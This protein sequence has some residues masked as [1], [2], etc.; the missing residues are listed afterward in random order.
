MGKAQQPQPSGLGWAL[1][2]VKELQLVRAT[3]AYP[4]SYRYNASGAM[5]K[6]A[7]NHPNYKWWAFGAV[8]IGNVSSSLTHSSAI[9]ALPS[10]ALHFQTDLPTVQWIILAEVLAT[11]ALLLPMGRLS[12]IIGRKQVY[13][14]GLATFAVGGALAGTAANMTTMIIAMLIQGC[15]AAMI[16]GIG[17]ALVASL[18][19]ANERGKGLGAHMSAI[20][21]GAVVG[22]ALGGLMIAVFG[23]RAV[24]FIPV[25]MSIIATAVSV[26]I[27]HGNVFNRDTQRPQ[28]DWLGAFLCAGALV[29][30]L[31]AMTHGYRAGLTS[32]LMAGTSAGFVFFLAAFIW[33]QLRTAS[34]LLDLKLFRRPVFAL[35]VSAGFLTFVGGTSVRFLMPFYL[36]TI[37][38]FTPAQVG[39]IMVPNA[40]C[41]IALGPLSGRLS[42][43]YGFRKFTVGGLAIST[44]GMLLLVGANQSTHLALLIAAMVLQ[45][46]GM[47]IFF[48]PNNSSI[49]SGVERTRYGIVSALVGL[50][51]NSGNLIGIAVPTAIVTVIMASMGYPASLTAAADGPHA[52][53]AGMRMAFL[54]QAVL[55]VLAML[56]SYK[57]VQG[58]PSP[59]TSEPTGSEASPAAEAATRRP[60]N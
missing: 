21:A 57:R 31:L 7:R 17:M 29:A 4:D 38:G 60:S 18:F 49:L 34:P 28:F 50:T 36:Q 25:P 56:M 15:G 59:D 48:S 6:S 43:R 47:G 3:F 2:W 30:L 40:L 51:R 14:A 13:M 42:D 10:V 5:I 39:L 46:G 37:I 19:P 58:D 53:V 55:L 24:F 12:D 1:A 11:S 26:A 32:P 54:V 41:I 20:G 45:S 52:F 16:Q 27:L 8:E 33:W 22:P 44:V 9:V 35:G 23:W